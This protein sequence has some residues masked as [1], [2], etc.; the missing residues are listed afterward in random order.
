MK[1]ICDMRTL[2][3]FLEAAK[4]RSV[5]R[6]AELAGI[7]QSAASQRLAALEKNLHVTL[8]DRSVRPLTLTHAGEVFLK[9][10]EDLI[11]NY[12]ALEQRVTSL[13]PRLDGRIRI[14]AIYSAGIDWLNRIA[15]AFGR[16]HP[17]VDIDIT[18]H[19]PETVHDIV[20]SGRS[21]LGIVSY[22][23][24]WRDVGVIP[25]RDE[26]MCVVC[27]P[28]H[29]LAQRFADARE[30]NHH[31]D[32]DSDTDSQNSLSLDALDALSVH[33]HELVD[34]EFV[35]L[36]CELPLGRRIRRYLREHSPTGELPEITHT[37]DNLDTIKAAVAVTDK[38]TILP[39]SSVLHEVQGH[40]LVA[41][42][43][44]PEIVRPL[45]VIYAKRSRQNG[46]GR[47]GEAILAPAAN[48]FVQ[49]LIK[50]A[51]PLSQQSGQQAG[52]QLGQQSQDENPNNSQVDTHDLVVSSTSDASATSMTSATSAMSDTTYAGDRT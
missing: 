14:E 27:A 2:Q 38:L 34:Y 35:T 10:V 36:E 19:R 45:G 7:T 46:S 25:L 49:Y 41:L 20:K 50:H 3:I 43:L 23:R 26:I 5:S 24:T 12:E 17:R 13:Q 39:R 11:S 37:F 9:G 4:L 44:V 33:A 15:D 47:N 31:H 52:Q 42:P 30:R 8:L 32:R 40:T 51:G 28:N 16:M 18:Y 1:N 22:P 29:P 48:T 6:A 21:D